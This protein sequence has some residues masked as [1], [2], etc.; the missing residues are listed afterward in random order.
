MR[1]SSSSGFF[2]AALR[3]CKRIA[4][5]VCCWFV[6]HSVTVSWIGLQNKTCANELGVILGS[7][8]NE[9]GTL[10]ERLKARLDKGLQL[11]RSGQVRMLFVSGGLG[12]EGFYEGDEM[13]KYLVQAGVPDSLV[14]ADNAG[15]NTEAT[16]RNAAAFVTSKNIRSVTIISQYFHLVRCRLLFRKAGIADCCIASPSYFEWRDSYSLIRE[17]AG[18]YVA[19]LN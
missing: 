15:N 16:A 1:D 12:K 9:D 3:W 19:L 11:Y 8:V 10:S 14:I 4:V 13:K 2:S 18:Y 17:F 7:K 5:F 6:F